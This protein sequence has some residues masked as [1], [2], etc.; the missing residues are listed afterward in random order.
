MS[1][2]RKKSFFSPFQPFKSIKKVLPKTLLWR[3][4]L[5]LIVPVISIQ[6]VISFVFFDRHLSKQTEL[7]S[8]NIAR[9]VSFAINYMEEHHP[10]KDFDQLAEKVERYGNIT[11]KLLNPDSKIMLESERLDWI[12]RYLLRS[13]QQH[14][15]APFDLLKRKDFLFIKVNMAE[16]TLLFSLE[17]KNLYTRTTTILIWWAVIT[18]F[19]FLLIAGIFMKNQIR[20]LKKLTIVVKDFGKGREKTFKPSGAYEVR[21]VGQAFNSMKDRIKRQMTQRTEMLAGVSHDLKTPLTRMKLELAFL[22]DSQAIKNLQN[23]VQQM[24]KMID[25]YLAFA[26][27]ADGEP[28]SYITINTLIQSL[29]RDFKHQKITLKLQKTDKKLFGRP[30]LLRRC[31]SNLLS[32]AARYAT[33]IEVLTLV[34]PKRINIIIDDNGPGIPADKREDV[35]KAF[36]RLEDSRNPDTGGTGLGLAIAK[37]IANAHGGKL[38]L[39]DSPTGGLRVILNLP[40]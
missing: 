39:D 24:S 33:S 14:V 25:E 37:D 11:M 7:L 1:R 9:N 21:K 35:F 34:H 40:L 29:K 23:D 28:F 17:E 30:V 6:I 3:T 31:L 18:P 20:P 19:L 15:K 8:D 10:H 26:R 27:G 5:I 4:L 12:D 16:S 2:L 36:Y 38:T 13:L 22:G 32:N